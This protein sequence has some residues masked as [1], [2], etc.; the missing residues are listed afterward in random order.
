MLHYLYLSSEFQM[1][2]ENNVI[3]N[4]PTSCNMHDYLLTNRNPYFGISVSSLGSHIEV[5]KVGLNILV[6]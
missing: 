4:L 5:G 3:E 1:D 2:C 6:S